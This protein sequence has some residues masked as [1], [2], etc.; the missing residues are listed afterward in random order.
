MVGR[1]QAAGAGA[2]G[3]AV[4]ARAGAVG[5]RGQQG[6]AQWGDRG[7][8]PLRAAAPAGGRGGRPSRLSCH[9]TPH[10]LLTCMTAGCKDPT[11]R[12]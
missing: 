5:G 6:L 10:H 9:L 11:L 2:E 8:P 12:A 3:M 4:A 7:R 1:A